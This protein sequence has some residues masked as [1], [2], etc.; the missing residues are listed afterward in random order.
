[1]GLL[2]NQSNSLM[3]PSP[4]MLA[5]GLNNHI[6]QGMNQPFF[7]TLPAYQVTNGNIPFGNMTNRDAT[8]M[9]L[10][11]LPGIGDLMSAQNIKNNITQG[12]Y[13]RALANALLYAAPFAI[14]GAGLLGMMSREGGRLPITPFS[15]QA[16]VI[17]KAKNQLTSINSL[18]DVRN[19]LNNND[20]VFVR[21]SS[22]HDLDMTPGKMSRDY[23]SGSNHAGISAVPL[24]KDMSDAE[25]AKYLKEY[26]FTRINHADSKPALYI[27]K[28]IG[29]D[30]DGYPSIQPSQMLGTLNNKLINQLD[31]GLADKL[32][33]IEKIKD[34]QNRFSKT[35]DLIGR[36]ILL[37][38]ILKYQNLLKNIK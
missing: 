22:N 35:P 37:N 29:K 25:L 38:S 21:W 13:G 31:N 20:N 7:G 10:N 4:N 33:L 24:S 27:G 9:A 36:Q 23:I 11:G 14:G 16:G 3:Y 2:D 34:A 15:K 30:S 32:S 12:L 18:D 17:G 26:S 6:Q 8:N 19:V 28:I 1:M 5:E